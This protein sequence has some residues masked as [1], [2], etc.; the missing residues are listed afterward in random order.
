[1]LSGVDDQHFILL[2]LSLFLS[3]FKMLVLTIKSIYYSLELEYLKDHLL[4]CISVA[5]NCAGLFHVPLLSDRCLKAD[6]YEGQQLLGN[7][8]P[9]VEFVF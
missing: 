5:F 7:G 2:L 8:D 6:V 3:H 4:L 9:T 1:M